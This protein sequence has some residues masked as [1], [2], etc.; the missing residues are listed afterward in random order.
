MKSVRFLLPF[1]ILS[2]V[3]SV[4]ACSSGS[5]DGN[6]DAIHLTVTNPTGY[7]VSSMTILFGDADKDIED[8][9]K[10]VSNPVFPYTY[11]LENYTPSPYY[12]VRLTV[13]D[14]FVLRYVFDSSA[15]GD[16]DVKFEVHAPGDYGD[17]TAGGALT[18]GANKASAEALLYP[19]TWYKGTIALGGTVWFKITGT[20]NTKYEIAWEDDWD[21]NPDDS[22]SYSAIVT[23]TV[24]DVADHVLA[25]AESG[26]TYPLQVTAPADGVFYVKF[27]ERD[28]PGTYAVGFD[29][30]SP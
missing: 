14:K 26:F 3:V 25:Q 15:G 19:R 16:H 27:V 23:G 29:T 9:T 11:D 12:F 4:I 18:G 30:V 6:A 7:A 1:V 20:P 13:N 28:G 17:W 24:Y 10:T 5:D 8:E 2:A 21:D 22:T